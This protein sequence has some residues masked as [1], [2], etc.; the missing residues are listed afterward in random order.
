MGAESL[1]WVAIFF[2]ALGTGQVHYYPV[3]VSCRRGYSRLPGP[4]MSD[5]FEAHARRYWSSSV[6]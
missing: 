5:V 4:A 3:A 6:C 2:F 1:A